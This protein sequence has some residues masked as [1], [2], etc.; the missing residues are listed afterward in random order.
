MCNKAISANALKKSRRRWLTKAEFAEV[1]RQIE[2]FTLEKYP[3]LAQ[4]VVYDKPR[5]REKL[6][7]QTHEQ[8]MKSRTGA[9]S[10][11]EGLKAQLH[12]VFARADSVADLQQQMAALGARLYVRGKSIGMIVQEA[13]ESERRHRLSSLGVEVHFRETEA[14]LARVPDRDSLSKNVF[15]IF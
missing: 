15:T 13:D 4:T 14:R 7:T 9:A 12:Q 1:Q 5:A 10:R 3:E 6:K 8:A 11:K 2:A